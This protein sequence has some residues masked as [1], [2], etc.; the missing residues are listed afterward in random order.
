MLRK[1]SVSLSVVLVSL[2]V[3]GCGA[4][5]PNDMEN[6]GESSQSLC[7]D[8]QPF[9]GA[10]T[11]SSGVV[12]YD[13]D[14]PTV[15]GC[16]SGKVTVNCVALSNTCNPAPCAT[17]RDMVRTAMA[18]WTTAT[19]GA[20]TFRPK[21]A[22]DVSY[23]TID[24][25][26]GAGPG[27]PGGGSGS[28]SHLVFGGVGVHAAAH[29]LGHV[30]NMYHHQQRSDRDTY[31]TMHPEGIGDDDGNHPGRTCASPDIAPDTIH[32]NETFTKVPANETYGVFDFQ[33]IML[34][35]GFTTTPPMT[36]FTKKDGSAVNGWESGTGN[37]TYKDGSAVLEHM[38]K[39]NGWGKFVGPDVAHSGDLNFNRSFGSGPVYATGA[40]GVCYR[41]DATPVLIR[42][43][44]GTD[45][46]LWL[47]EGTSTNWT[48]L[49]T[50]VS[51]TSPAC[52]SWGPD[53][54][55][56]VVLGTDNVFYKI[57]YHGGAWEAGPWSIGTPAGGTPSAP[58]I[59]AWGPDRLDVFSIAGGSL[60]WKRW[61][62][63]SWSGWSIPRTVPSG[64]L[65]TGS[66]GAASEASGKIAVAARGNNGKLYL[67]EYTDPNWGAS[68]SE[69]GVA[70]G[71]GV[72]SPSVASWGSGRIDF[73][74]TG[75]SPNNFAWIKSRVSGTWYGWYPM[76]G[77]LMQPPAIAAATNKLDVV[78]LNQDNSN[79]GFGGVWEKSW[80][81]L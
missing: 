18:G 63:I 45:L 32:Y 5:D 80:R 21:T 26:P 60:L 68:W 50:T 71:S 75:G 55:D 22:G 78:A 74:V 41:K 48:R 35:T 33:S 25:Q 64:V 53:R 57:G 73:V 6:L 8:A 46:R 13:F 20:I 27:E 59:A 12:P 4:P 10:F 14:H 36:G 38:N 65:F 16:K 47:R 31:L 37:P 28:P 1:R 58:A 69:I 56:V 23:V 44:T 51:Q 30:L 11:W 34:Y 70:N 42:T 9:Q 67:L 29:E 15:N 52:A 72:G 7:L 81:P 40:P 49:G 24:K 79:I 77:F 17:E 62:G 66:P 2:S 61:N 39:A 54:V 76:G 43:V 3:A 19:G